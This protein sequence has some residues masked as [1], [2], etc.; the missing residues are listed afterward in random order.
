MN[1]QKEIFGQIPSGET[2]HLYTLTNTHGVEVKITNYGGIVVSWKVPDR[3]G[4]FG[5]VVLGYDRLS[6]YLANNPYFG[7]IVGRYGNRIAKGK[8]SLNGK[9]Y[10]LAVNNGP[11]HLHGGLQGFDKVLWQ[12]AE[13]ITGETVGLD[14]SYRSRDGE[15]GYPGNLGVK[16]KYTLNN[17][18]QLRID[19][20]AT[21]DA[22]TVTN[23]TNHSYFN[24]AGKGDILGHVLWLNAEHFIPVDSTLIPT[25]EIKSLN[26]SPLDFRQP[27]AIGARIDV[28]DEQIKFGLGYDHN[29][30]LNAVD[31]SLRQIARVTEPTSGRVLEVLSTEPGVQFYS[32]NFLDG[33]NI[34]KGGQV[35]AYRN[36]FCLET[37]HYPDSPNQPSF[38]STVLNPGE[39]RQSI[40]IYQISTE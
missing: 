15:E 38:P 27:T 35:Y 22:P 10:T 4:K 30:V 28:A 8:F 25:G 39:T 37:Q 36:G 31:G 3:E 1:L 2:A 17:L 13:F 33:T 23:L 21:T 7:C 19:Y 34:G 16:V 32:G 40:T 14:L 9:E 12:A 29:F 20:E 26:G 24:L 11:N 6:D 5:D 18:N